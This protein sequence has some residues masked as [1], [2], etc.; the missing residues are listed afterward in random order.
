MP[1]RTLAVD[2]AKERAR[3]EPLWS[4]GWHAESDELVGGD[5]L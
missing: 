3:R 5:G 2:L 1:K 4:C